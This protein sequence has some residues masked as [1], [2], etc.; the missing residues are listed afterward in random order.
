MPHVTRP[1]DQGALRA[2]ALATGMTVKEFGTFSGVGVTM[3]HKLER[4]GR[5]TDDMLGRINAALKSKGV[6]PIVPTDAPV[7]EHIEEAAPPSRQ[8]GRNVE[9]VPSGFIAHA[10]ETLGVTNQELARLAGLSAASIDNYKRNGFCPLSFRATVNGLL[11]EHAAGGTKQLGSVPEKAAKR[12]YVNG[13]FTLLVEET[14]MSAA[15]SLLATHGI[16]VTVTKE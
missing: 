3:I 8:R 9:M 4:L 16:R 14:D 10:I 7:A 5:I 15:V 6:A 13:R 12:R 11:A 2:A 1:F